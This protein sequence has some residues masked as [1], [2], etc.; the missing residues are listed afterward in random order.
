MAL[1]LKRGDLWSPGFS[2]SGWMGCLGSLM[3]LVLS[4]HEL[5]S[6][7]PGKAKQEGSR[8]QQGIVVVSVLYLGRD[9]NQGWLFSCVHNQVQGVDSLEGGQST[10]PLC[11][12]PRRAGEHRGLR[13]CS[14]SVGTLHTP[15][16]GCGPA[17]QVTL[18]YTPALG[19]VPPASA[20]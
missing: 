11:P 4:L 17:M 20:T 12:P 3:V 10:G 6:P 18:L 8:H 14:L 15:T 19:D 16:V 5:G 13:S 9:W 1:P 2:I 7:Q